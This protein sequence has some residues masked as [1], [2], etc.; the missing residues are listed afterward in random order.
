M[1]HDTSQTINGHWIIKSIRVDTLSKLL[2]KLYGGMKLRPNKVGNLTIIGAI[3]DDTYVG[4]IDIGDESVII[5]PPESFTKGCPK[6]CKGYCALNETFIH[7]SHLHLFQH[8]FLTQYTTLKKYI[9]R[10]YQI[11]CFFLV[12]PFFLLF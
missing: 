6:V 4:Y 2:K 7:Y 12:F 11:R 3:E 9:L 8:L 10:P 1:L 5:N